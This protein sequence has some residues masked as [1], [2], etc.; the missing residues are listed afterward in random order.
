MFFVLLFF[1][2]FL[3]IC[4]LLGDFSFVLYRS[5]C[6]L[7][8]DW[9][10]LHLFMFCIYAYVVC[11]LY[12]SVC[13]WIWLF[14]LMFCLFS[15]TQKFTTFTFHVRICYDGLIFHCVFVYFT[16]V[17]GMCVC[18]CVIVRLT[19][20]LN[21]IVRWISQFSPGKNCNIDVCVVCSFLFVFRL[22]IDQQNW[23]KIFI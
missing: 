22:I 11:W 14:L 2:F 8:I 7:F 12:V 6:Y 17:F 5:G 21:S 15:T 10:L 18:M 20:I 13:M 1:A 23:L 4:F 16:V 19:T 3:W 9:L